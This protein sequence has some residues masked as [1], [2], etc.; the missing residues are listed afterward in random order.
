M[1][2]HLYDK[3]ENRSEVAIGEGL[4]KS[5]MKEF[6]RVWRVEGRDQFCVLIVSWLHDSKF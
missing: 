1:A 2:F 5:S 4:Q 3:M 6:G